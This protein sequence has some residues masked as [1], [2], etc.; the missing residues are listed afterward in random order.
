MI[1]LMRKHPVDELK[2]CLS[3]LGYD[4]SLYSTKAKPFIIS[5]QTMGDLRVRIG[6]ALT[7]DLNERARDLMMSYYLDKE[8]AT[9]AVQT[10]EIVVFRHYF[11]NSYSVAFGAINKT[12][13]EMEVNFK[14]NKSKNMI[15]SPSKGTVRSVIPPQGLIYL[16]TAI[17]DPG[18]SSFSYSYSFSA[19]RT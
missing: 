18:Q 7:T 5:F 3:L 2:K 6:N 8:G 19:G 16:S 10:N 4:E 14:M 9:G 13:D 1:Q 15:Y 11:P 17:L 12:E